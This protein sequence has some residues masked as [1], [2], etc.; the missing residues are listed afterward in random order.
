MQNIVI[1]KFNQDHGVIKLIETLEKGVQ[2]LTAID[3]KSE[4]ANSYTV[5]IIEKKLPRRIMLL[6]LEEE[7]KGIHE[8]RFDNLLEFLKKQRK[9]MER[10]VQQNKEEFTKKKFPV[11]HIATERKDI[12]KDSCLLHPKSSHFTRKCK[13]FLSKTVDERAQVLKDQGA[14]R[15]CLSFSFWQAMSMDWQMEPMW[16]CRL[17][18]VTLKISTWFNYLKNF[19]CISF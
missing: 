17:Q 10:L 8:N 7:E 16:S 9:M 6:W 5:K 15:L 19:S 1:P 11:G 18:G 14:C 4:I 13:D 3:K 2:D 12:V